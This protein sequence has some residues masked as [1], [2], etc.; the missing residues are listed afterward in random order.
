MVA[1]PGSR[2][3]TLKGEDEQV[4]ARVIYGLAGR[5]IQSLVTGV[6][7]VGGDGRLGPNLTGIK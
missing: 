1:L 2:H 3:I 6:G 5:V 7:G 4:I